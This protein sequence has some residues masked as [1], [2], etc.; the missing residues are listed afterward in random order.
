MGVGN[1]GS[2]GFTTRDVTDAPSRRVLAGTSP[3]QRPVTTPVTTEVHVEACPVQTTWEGSGRCRYHV[4]TAPCKSQSFCAAM[5]PKRSQ[6][7]RPAEPKKGSSLE[8]AS[9]FLDNV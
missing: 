3:E 6:E 4:R 7:T 5:L 2:D 1:L 8:G 9:R